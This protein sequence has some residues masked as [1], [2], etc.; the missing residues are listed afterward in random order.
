MK[1][2]IAVGKTKEYQYLKKYINIEL[3]PIAINPS[4]NLSLH[5]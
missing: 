2:K 5:L 1:S 4:K 3:N